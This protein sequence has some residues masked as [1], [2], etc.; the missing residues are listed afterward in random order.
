MSQNTKNNKPRSGS[1]PK[2]EFQPIGSHIDAQSEYAVQLA[3]TLS[4]YLYMLAVDL[5]QGCSVIGDVKEYVFQTPHRKNI[6][7]LQWNRAGTMLLTCSEDTICLW[8]STGPPSRAQL[9]LFKSFSPD[10]TRISSASLVER[11]DLAKIGMNAPL[12]LN[13]NDN[14]SSPNLSE[15][16]AGLCVLI[17]TFERLLS[18]DPSLELDVL[19]SVGDKPLMNAGLINKISVGPEYQ[20]NDGTGANSPRVKQKGLIIATSSGAKESNVSLVR[21]TSPFFL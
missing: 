4:T 14:P 12:D 10:R 11:Y 17:G 6:N 20:E 7:T 1:F 16:F 8:S 13:K 5:P 21:L 3:C 19:Q 15:T 2:M 18:W 9:K